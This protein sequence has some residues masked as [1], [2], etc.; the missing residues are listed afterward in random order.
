MR[1]IAKATK[2]VKTLSPKIE[3][4]DRAQF[5]SKAEGKPGGSG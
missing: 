2:L 5:L 1:G 3:S 4:G